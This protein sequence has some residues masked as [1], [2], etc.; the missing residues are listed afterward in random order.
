[1]T[2]SL[3]QIFILFYD[4]RVGILPETSNIQIAEG[5]SQFSGFKGNS[6]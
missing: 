2:I 3:L 6:C 5:E 1:M 4:S